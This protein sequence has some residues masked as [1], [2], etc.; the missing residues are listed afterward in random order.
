MPAEIVRGFVRA[1]PPA[2]PVPGPAFYLPVYKGE[3]VLVGEDLVPLDA[4]PTTL[5]ESSWQYLGLL[6]G[7]PCVTAR[8]QA[9]AILPEGTQAWGLRSLYGKLTDDAYA[10][11]GYALQI[12]NWQ[13]TYKFCPRCGTGTRPLANSWA[14][15]CPACGLTT[16]PPVSPAVLALV[17]DGGDRILLAQKEGWGTRYSILAGFVE[18]GETFEQCVLRE[19][20]EEAGIVVEAPQYY[21][22][23]PWPFPHQIM[24]GFTT[25]YV[26]GDIVIDMTELSHAE[27]FHRD[28]LPDL[29]PPLSLSRQLIERWRAKEIGH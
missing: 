12:L 2:A 20:K 13:D 22:S 11:A 17:H 24:V 8:L 19:V 29:P 10:L 16:Y 26:E 25:R 23:Q 14:Q 6:D 4:P 18:P 28:Q 3:I 7:V 9:D 27:W 21:G 1:Y 15:E 5:L